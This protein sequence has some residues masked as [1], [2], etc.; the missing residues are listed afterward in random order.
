[1]HFGK[2]RRDKNDTLF[3]EIIRYGVESC[4]R[5]RRHGLQLQAA[6]IVGRTYKSTRWM[7]EPLRNAI[8]LCMPCHTWFDEH[9]IKAVIFDAGKR[10]FDQSEEGNTF[11]VERCG[12]TWEDLQK[13]Y[14]LAQ[15][16]CRYTA[17]EKKQ[18]NDYLK[19]YMK[20]LKKETS[21]PKR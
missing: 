13:I 14:I 16:A 11:L 6:H 12:Y 5:C 17:F 3:S 15:R 20:K 18:V 8:P 9:R 4:L 10:V 7:L 2:I 1:M 19:S 21:C